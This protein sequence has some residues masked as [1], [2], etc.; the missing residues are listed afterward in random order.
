M[1]YSEEVKKAVLKRIADGE[2]VKNIS[3]DLGISVATLYKWKNSSGS[4]DIESETEAKKVSVEIGEL[5]LENKLEEAKERCKEFPK[6]EPIQSQYI[7]ILMKEGTKESLEEAKEKCKEFSKYEPIQL[8]YIKILIN[9]GTRESLTKAQKICNNPY[10]R[11]NKHI[12]NKLQQINMA[13]VFAPKQESRV[14]SE[15]TN[16]PT[17]PAN[18]FL[19]EIRTR[20]Y[21][22]D[23]TP[24]FIEQIKKNESGLDEWS[25]TI[26]LVAIYDKQKNVKASS[27]ALKAAKKFFESDADK[28]KELNKLQ[29]VVLSK[30]A[31]IFDL[32][33]FDQL[34]K[35]TMDEEIHNQILKRRTE[36]TA[37]EQENI[38]V[39]A[40]PVEEKTLPKKPK[41]S[42]KIITSK[43]VSVENEVSGK[44]KNKEKKKTKPKNS[45]TPNVKKEQT[46]GMIFEEEMKQIQIGAY[47]RANGIDFYDSRLKVPDM[48][49]KIPPEALQDLERKVKQ[50][51]LAFH[52]LDTAEKVAEKPISNFRAKMQL[53]VLLRKYGMTEI[54]YQKLET[55]SEIY[56]AINHMVAQQMQNPRLDNTETLANV[57]EKIEELKED[58]ESAYQFVDK[59]TL[60]YKG[61]ER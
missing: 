2:K 24:Q 4:N 26:A 32:N 48:K 36:A 33:R 15:I 18:S 21:D 19:N 8:Q 52:D 1:A 41:E 37:V 55:E 16:D 31:R 13:L 49:Y 20:L 17:A 60:K 25:K 12:A 40:K 7:T 27:Q 45:E 23:I 42:P 47:Q 34:L 28:V 3:E 44:A 5:I 11:N 6:Y 10:F 14:S 56:D 22:D 54:A 29:D 58:K 43:A 9:E 30:K 38:G 59:A 57:I 35:W 39:T 51:Q 61:K 46:I 50:Q 53:I